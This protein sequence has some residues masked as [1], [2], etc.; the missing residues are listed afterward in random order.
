MEHT[1]SLRACYSQRLDRTIAPDHRHQGRTE[2]SSNRKEPLG[3]ER[4]AQ[5]AQRDP[6]G[7]AVIEPRPARPAISRAEHPQE[8]GGAENERRHAVSARHQRLRLAPG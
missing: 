1:F 3:I 8:R 7:A 6:P 2:A 4:A 5:V